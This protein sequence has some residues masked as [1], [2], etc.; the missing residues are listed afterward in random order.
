L[1]QAVLDDVDLP[2]LAAGGIATARGLAAVLAAG[3]VGAW[4]GTA[5][6]ACDE[7]AYDEARRQG[8]V[9]AGLDSTVYTTVFDI[10]RGSPWPSEFGGR[11]VRNAFSDTW[12]G[13]ADE[14][15][16][17]P[18]HST[19]SVLWAGQAVGLVHAR[20]PAGDVVAD[21]AGAEG[22]LAEVC[23]GVTRG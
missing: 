10:G 8:A 18:V 12:Y 14:L 21:L 19:E 20:R 13:R 16:A 6:I 15:L 7:S 11:A 2:V 4:V 22:L 3:A 17:D 9:E 23:R 5:F 1:L